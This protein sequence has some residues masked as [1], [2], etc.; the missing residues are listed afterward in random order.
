Y[1]TRIYLGYQATESSDIQNQNNFSINDYKN[2]FLT[3]SF[4]YADYRVDDFLF[5]EKT[6]ATVRLGIGK[7]E[8]NLSTNNQLF[9]EI[10]LAHNLYLNEKNI[11][12]IR[13]ENYFLNSDQYIINELYRFGGI[14]S[15][16][17]FNENS[18]QANFLTSLL[19]EYRYVLAPNLYLHSIIDYGYFRDDSAENSGGLLGIGFGFGLLTKKGL[20]NLVY[21]KGS[22]D[23]QSN[24]LGNSI[25]HI[26][27]KTNF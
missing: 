10:N 18:L 6:A 20:L 21:A 14:N 11:F 27:F 13:S 7:R 2:T 26:R 1:N 19:T 12:N 5:P 9:A 22:T 25:V 23:E 8:A 24:K 16:R 17:G 4:E 15:I 3:S